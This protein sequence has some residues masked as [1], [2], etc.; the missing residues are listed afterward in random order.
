MQTGSIKQI[1]ESLNQKN[2]NDFYI[3]YSSYWGYCEW[4]CLWVYILVTD[5]FIISSKWKNTCKNEISEIRNILSKNIS[6]INNI[7]IKSKCG[8]CNDW[9]DT[10]IEINYNWEIKKKKID[11]D[12]MGLTWDKEFLLNIV[13]IMGNCWIN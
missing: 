9:I 3:K 12:A 2:E 10:E 13:K 11:L 8:S 4:W 5:D 6:V 7:N 1:T